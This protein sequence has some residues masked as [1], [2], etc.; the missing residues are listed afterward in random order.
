MEIVIMNQDD[1]LLHIQQQIKE[2]KEYL[3][4][5]HVTLRKITKTNNFLE[6][7]KN[8]YAKYHEYIVH[9]KQDQIEALKLLNDYIEDLT[10]TGKISKQQVNDAKTEQ[11]HILK[12]LDAIKKSL[13]DIIDE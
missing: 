6:D 4:N 12:E 13:D 3:L 2:K 9:Q 7:V 10:L 5:K 8:D 11:Q 1:R